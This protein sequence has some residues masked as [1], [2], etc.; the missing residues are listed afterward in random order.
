MVMIT[1]LLRIPRAWSLA[2]H[3]IL[4]LV[5]AGTVTV[6]A[7][8]ALLARS[9]AKPAVRI[10]VDHP[11]LSHVY[12]TW[13]ELKAASTLVIIGTTGTPQ[14]THPQFEGH[15][16]ASETWTQT[17]ISIERT[18]LGSAPQSLTILQMGQPSTSALDV[19]SDFPILT[20]GVR[21]LLFLTPSP[22][23]G[24]WY[25]VGATQG[26][27]PVTGDG[28]VNMYSDVG[29]PVHDLPLDAVI[30]AELMAPVPPS[31]R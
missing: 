13:S 1:T 12:S 14:P 22:I 17:P 25:P 7:H 20:S 29:I 11:S 18:L 3:G 23:A 15:Q 6:G 21:Y 19:E 26:V 27:F 24:Q 5:L 9:I 30:N 16:V 2:C 31:P 28:K 8:K 10:E 4:A